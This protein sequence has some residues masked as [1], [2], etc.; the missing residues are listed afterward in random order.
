MVMRELLSRGLA[1]DSVIDVVGTANDAY[2]ARDKIISL[3]PDV[4]TLD[5]EMPR[6]NG[7]EFLKMLMPQY[8]MPVI[9]VSS[10]SGIVFDAMNAGAIDFVEKKGRPDEEWMKELI[11]KVKIA[12]VS[13]IRQRL[14][15]PP[16]NHVPA[17][18]GS[19]GLINGN[20]LIAI[21]ASTGGTEALH[22]VLRVLPANVPP[23]VIV[24]HM[25]PVFTRLYAERINQ[26]CQMEV[27]EAQKGDLLK[28]G[29]AL[30]APGDAHIRVVKNGS[31]YF[32]DVASGE[33]VSGHCPSVDVLFHSVADN[34]K[35]HPLGI[36]LTGMG[37]DGA[38]GLLQMRQNGAQT[39]GQDEETSVVYG[40]PKVAY[41]IGAVQY[42]LGIRDIPY[43]LLELV[44]LT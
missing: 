20:R 37:S 13:K 15:R 35:G 10:V 22:E 14:K 6:L 39:L 17:N 41:E 2:M 23:I 27:R 19:K 33:K 29:L 4:M 36:I 44:T 21:G 30:I 43:K 11:F 32:L 40:M 38:K 7:I 24:Q 31:N 25:P 9:V 18:E 8:P 3:R 12:S 26:T 28:P 16:I 1:E 34:Y 5:V 42:Q